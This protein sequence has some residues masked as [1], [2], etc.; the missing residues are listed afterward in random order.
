MLISIVLILYCDEHASIQ[1]S[2]TS[3][4]MV[5]KNDGHRGR[6]PEVMKRLRVCIVLRKNP[7]FLSM[8]L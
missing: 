1:F 8:A 7:I 4:D 3:M 5:N 6:V 2:L